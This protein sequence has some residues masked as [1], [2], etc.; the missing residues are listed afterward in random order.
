MILAGIAGHKNFLTFGFLS[1]NI[2]FN[3]NEY[4]QEKAVPI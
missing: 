3:E 2:F 4:H 1:G